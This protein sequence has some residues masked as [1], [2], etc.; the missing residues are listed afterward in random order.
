MKKIAYIGSLGLIGIIT[1]E[2]G[3]IGILP[4][5]A[6]SYHITI[7]KAGLL[8][9]AFAMVIA[10]AGPVMTLAF[11]GYNRKTVMAVSLSLFVVTGVVSFLSPPFWLL[12]VVRMLPAFLQPVYISTAIA[13][14]TAAADKKAEHR[15]MAIVLGGIGIATITTVPFAT[16]IA[17]ITSRWQASFVVQTAVSILALLA[18]LLLL[19]SM[20]VK[21]RIAFGSQLR[22]L[23]KPVFLVSAGVVCAM[24][25]AMFTTYSYF[26]DYLGQVYG[27]DARMISSMLLLFG[28]AGVIGNVVA[29]KAL[30]KS[31]T[32]T[33]AIW[34]V[35]LTVISGGIY[36]AGQLPLLTVIL[37]TVWG[38]LHT[39]CFLTGQAYMIAAAPEAPEFAN[40]LSIS[41]G[42]LGISVGTAVSGWVI[43][44]YGVQQAP[45]S[46][47]A[48]GVVAL[49]LMGLKSRLEKNV[50]TVARV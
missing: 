15:M 25:A 50:C 49:L 10:L 9:S 36:Y 17:G 14:A 26:A 31:I 43:A 18:V 33:T 12:L 6:A 28:V 2:F 7:D 13:A 29:G 4:Q 27:M 38:V 34:L 19:P 41:F 30:G 22:I 48:F 32:G 37:I 45:W 11:S 39:P 16:Y 24:N 42:N 35:G 8:L 3:V 46:M 20:P 21:Q 5:V 1:T 47:L 44:Q 40:S 23:R